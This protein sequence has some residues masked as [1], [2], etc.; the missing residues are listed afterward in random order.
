MAT[1]IRSHMMALSDL[2]TAVEENRKFTVFCIVFGSTVALL[3][4]GRITGDNFV[5]IS[6]AVVGLFM[7]G[8]VGEHWARRR[9]YEIEAQQP[10]GWGES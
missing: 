7:A 4:F 6:I 1:I 5:D 10:P 9:Q 3:L 2:Q 8:N